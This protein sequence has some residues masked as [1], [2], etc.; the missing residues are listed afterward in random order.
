MNR[1]EQAA[2]SRVIDATP[3]DIYQGRIKNWI[4][5]NAIEY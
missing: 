1:D 4:P 2:T 5:G 3:A